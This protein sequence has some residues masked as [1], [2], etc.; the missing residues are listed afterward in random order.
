MKTVYTLLSALILVFT[1]QT[2]SFAQSTDLVETFKKHFNNTVETVKKTDDPAKKRT[3]LNNSFDKM[4]STIDQIES[5]GTLTEDDH[6]RLN[7]LKLGLIEKQ[8]ELNGVEGFNEITD[9][10]LDEFSDYAQD[11]LEQAN[12]RTITIGVTTAILILLVLL[13]I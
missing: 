3:I 2:V 11:Y 9:E 4:I 6:G 5:L 8:N 7:V 12:N 13:L 10:N 1:V